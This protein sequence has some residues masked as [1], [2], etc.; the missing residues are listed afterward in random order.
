[1]THSNHRQG[2]RENLANDWVMLSLPYRGPPVIAE[3]VERYNEICRR[4]HPINPD[5][6]RGWYIWVF[7]DRDKMEGALRE[8]AEAELGLSVVVSGLFDDVAECC[9]RAG[10]RAHTVNHSLG[11]W[12]RTEKLPPREV[13]E[14]TTMCGH[15]LIAPGL[16][17]H[18][19]ER[20]RRDDLSAAAACQEMRK[21]CICDIFNHVRAEG[22]MGQL[23]E[24][25]QQGRLAPPR[26]SRGGAGHLRGWITG[27]SREE[28]AR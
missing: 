4:H 11:F 3:K 25:M 23:V 28:A 10:T 14:I 13:L 21:V 15:A 20:V 24:A 6:P 27:L 9:Q 26:P 17:W 8:L 22:L 7:D 18:L 5:R 1:V 19:A 2:T 16:V 12:G